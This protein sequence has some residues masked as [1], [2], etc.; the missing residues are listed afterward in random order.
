MQRMEFRKGWV[1]THLMEDPIPERLS[2][3]RWRKLR[4]AGSVGGGA[5]NSNGT[6]MPPEV[7]AGLPEV[8]GDFCHQLTVLINF[9]LIKN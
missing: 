1:S 2:S 5:G 4:S 7:A 6:R 9:L 3:E 8:L